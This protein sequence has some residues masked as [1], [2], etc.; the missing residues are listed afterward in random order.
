MEEEKMGA[1]DFVKKIVKK[2]KKK[3]EEFTDW[4]ED[5]GNDA[6]DAAAGAAEDAGNAFGDLLGDN[7]FG[8][9]VKHAGAIIAS[10]I[11]S[12]FDTIGVGIGAAIK[13]AVAVATFDY[14]LFLEGVTDVV[15]SAVGNVIVTVGHTLGLL[16][17]LITIQDGTLRYLTNEEKTLLRRVFK[18]SLNYDVIKIIIGNTGFL[19]VNSRP[20]VL[21]NTIYFKFNRRTDELLVH[22]CTHVWQY[23]NKGNR[24]AA[25][26]IYSQLFVPDEY[27]WEREIN[28]RDKDDWNDFNAEAQAKFF[29]DLWVE[30]KLVDGSGALIEEGN[31]RFYDADWKN[32]F[33]VFEITHYNE[34]DG[35][36]NTFDYT[37]IAKRAVKTVRNP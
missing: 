24:Y 10:T 37:D 19:G 27:N 1:L 4:I 23:Q 3:V 26:A 32:E 16:G 17:T 11:K 35:T 2:A 12:V 34:E 31:G 18:K 22:E 7:R 15:S 21:G 20:M 28:V 13:T 6:G 14:N 8:N 33:G 29:E 30:G 9:A 5:K 36:E 25:D